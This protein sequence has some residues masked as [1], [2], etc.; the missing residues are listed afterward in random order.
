[1]LDKELKKEDKR[2]SDLPSSLKD[3]I[4]KAE[5]FSGAITYQVYQHSVLQ[6]LTFLFSNILLE[7]F[8]SIIFHPPCF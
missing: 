3:K 4:E 2:Q 5:I 6:E 7:S 1:V 8:P